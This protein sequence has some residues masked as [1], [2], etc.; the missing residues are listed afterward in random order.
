[1]PQTEAEIEEIARD[2]QY[3]VDLIWPLILQ[4]V[5]AKRGLVNLTA[6]AGTAGE[7]RLTSDATR[8]AID[9]VWGYALGICK[10]RQ[11]RPAELVPQTALALGYFRQRLADNA[12]RHSPED[13]REAQ[14][15]I[16][17][18]IDVT[19]REALVGYAAGRPVFPQAEWPTAWF[20]L[21]RRKAIAA[22][23][24]VLGAATAL[25]LEKLA[26]FVGV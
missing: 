9:H 12:S 18:H 14:D 2:I 26:D 13:I 16:T 19:S 6:T 20:E 4:D 7:L 17:R 8:G 21:G 3:R 11:I 24:F 23:I 25:L 15:A 1:M 10:A 5:Q 22:A